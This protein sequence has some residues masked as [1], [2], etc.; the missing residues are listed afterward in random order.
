MEMGNNGEITT[1]YLAKY[2][3]EM[4]FMDGKAFKKKIPNVGTVFCQ[5]WRKTKEWCLSLYSE[6]DKQM[7]V[8]VETVS[9]FWTA[10]TLFHVKQHIK[11]N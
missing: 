5:R 6:D 11:K 1:E 2:I 3:D 9:E 4:D 7:Q 10:L 8:F